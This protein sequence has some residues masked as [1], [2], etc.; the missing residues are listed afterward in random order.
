MRV[1]EAVKEAWKSVLG[2]GDTNLIEFESKQTPFFE[3]WGNPIAAFG[4]AY[5][6][7]Q[8]GFNVLMEDIIDNSTIALRAHL[9]STIIS[10]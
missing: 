10:T 9:P 5:F 1:R 7:C 2:C 4:V 8:R 3:I 6:Y